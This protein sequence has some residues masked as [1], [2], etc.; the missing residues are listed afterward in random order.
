M[1]TES[2]D[3]N[4]I[5]RVRGMLK[6]GETGT[7]RDKDAAG[8]AIVVGDTRASW[9]I[10]ERTL[11]VRIADFHAFQH[12]D[13][14]VELR[15]LT[16]RVRTA[17]KNGE[18]FKTLIAKFLKHRNVETAQQHADIAAGSGKTWEEVR[19]GFLAWVADHRNKDTVRNYRSALGAVEGGAMSAD[20]AHLAGKPV[21]AITTQDLVKVRASIV[22]RGGGGGK[23]RQADLT[24]SALKSCFKWYVN[25]DDALIALSP[26]QPLSKVM[27]RSTETEVDTETERT[28]SQIEIGQ[29]LLALPNVPNASARLATTISL[30]TGQRRMTPLKTRKSAIK[31]HPGYGMVWRLSDKVAAWRVLPLP[32]TAAEAVR[33]ALA[34]SRD[35]NLYL[36]PQLRPSKKGRSMNGHM[37]ERR[38]SAVLETMREPG[39]P[40][41]AL[42]FTP[43]SHHLRRTFIS[44]MGPRMHD[45]SVG[46]KRLTRDD[47]EMI[48][49]ADEGRKT[50][51]TSVYDQHEYLDVK[52]RILEAFETWCLEGLELARRAAAG[53]KAA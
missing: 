12:I 51:A 35:D 25:R 52:L 48:T 36:F 14:I 4:T 46:E 34:M 21:V 29:L 1:A 8:L 10:I 33:A 3:G 28:F 5:K 13:D 9:R 40:L 31:D 16:A 43:S 39:G 6:R 18:D 11:K 22:R 38:V 50:T 24:V 45:F 23:L 2:I 42:P 27:E 47:V 20:F 53:V 19:D 49:H 41:S 44:V 17:K 7:I 15:E 32:K 37:S 26:A 30:L